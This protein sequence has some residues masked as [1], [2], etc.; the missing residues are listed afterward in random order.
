MCL[1]CAVRRNTCTG[2]R[3]YSEEKITLFSMVI[4][5]FLVALSVSFRNQQSGFKYYELT[6]FNG[7][8]SAIFD[9]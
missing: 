9:F 4:A 6:A 2:Q 5:Q 8:P 3:G 7:W 1:L